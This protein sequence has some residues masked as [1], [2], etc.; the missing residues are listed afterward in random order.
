[1]ENKKYI[2]NNCTDVCL[3]IQ[4]TLYIDEDLRF[5]SCQAWCFSFCS[6]WCAYLHCLVELLCYKYLTVW[7]LQTRSLIIWVCRELVLALGESAHLSFPWFSCWLSVWFWLNILPVNGRGHSQHEESDQC[8]EGLGWNG[9]LPL[10]DIQEKVEGNVP[11][12]DD[13]FLMGQHWQS[14]DF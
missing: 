7:P 1:M 2:G 6:L 14:V 13:W 5:S 12:R 11:C 9:L 8:S 4:W 3:Y 10:L